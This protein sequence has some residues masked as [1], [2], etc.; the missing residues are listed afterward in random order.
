MYLIYCYHFSFH[1]LKRFYSILWCSCAVFS[2]YFSNPLILKWVTEWQSIS[3][4]SS[5]IQSP[6]NSRNPSIL[7]ASKIKWSYAYCILSFSVRLNK[8]DEYLIYTSMWLYYSLRFVALYKLIAVRHQ[9]LNLA[10]EINRSRRFH[11]KFCCILI[12]IAKIFCS[13]SI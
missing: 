11:C 12:I 3:I 2:Q 7:P 10:V 1:F 9:C 8:C 4:S 6:T 13:T 5:T